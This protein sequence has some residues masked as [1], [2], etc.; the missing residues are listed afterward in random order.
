MKYIRNSILS[1]QV[2]VC[3]YLVNLEVSLHP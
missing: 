2:Q 1:E 3:N